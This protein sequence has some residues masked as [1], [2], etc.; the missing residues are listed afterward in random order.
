MARRSYKLAYETA[1]RDFLKNLEKRTRLDKEI[2]KLKDTLQ[3]LGK[4]CG[5]DPDETDKLFLGEGFAIDGKPGFTNAIRQLFRIHQTDLS[6]MDVRDGLHKMSVGEGQ[7]NLLSSIH[8][9]LRRMAE[10]GEIEKT[11]DSKFRARTR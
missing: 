7:V 10:A 6:P 5:I 8:T 1:K 2:R 3:A 11:G 4:L 9:V